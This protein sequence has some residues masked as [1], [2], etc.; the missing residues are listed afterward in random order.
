[1]ILC[2][3]EIQTRSY[4]IILSRIPT[5]EHPVAGILSC[6]SLFCHLE[7]LCWVCCPWSVV[8]FLHHN[9]C[10]PQIKVSICTFCNFYSTMFHSEFQ[11]FDVSFCN[12]N[13]WFT[14]RREQTFLPDFIAFGRILCWCFAISRNVKG[15][16]KNTVENCFDITV[17]LCISFFKRSAC[18]RRS[19]PLFCTL[20][21][22][23]TYP[24]KVDIVYCF[25]NVVCQAHRIHPSFCG[26]CG[27][28]TAAQF[29]HSAE[30]WAGPVKK[31][32]NLFDS[33]IFA[34]TDRTTHSA[35]IILFY[36]G[37]HLEGKSA[38][39]KTPSAAE[40]QRWNDKCP[41]V[42][43]DAGKHCDGKSVR[44]IHTASMYPID[45]NAADKCRHLIITYPSAQVN[46]SSEKNICIEWKGVLDGLPHKWIFKHRV[47]VT[48][49]SEVAQIFVTDVFKCST[50]SQ[51]IIWD[52]HFS[53]SQTR[54][55]SVGLSIDRSRDVLYSNGGLSIHVN[56]FSVHN[57]LWPFS[58]S[59]GYSGTVIE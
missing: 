12:L 48:L 22:P 56:R 29:C 44:I 38:G 39:Y 53:S 37:L 25:H 42:R 45:N 1:M 50:C 10:L 2:N 27:N 55:S 51:N 41:H 40:V 13:F 26:L 49:H 6:R 31:N 43:T 47:A 35:R 52:E 17:Y 23:F 14:L 3:I 21:Y 58:E 7:D 24:V 9:R 5:E 34:Q 54:N 46:I 57:G 33:E 11:L 28:C 8:R 32:P 18:C 30:Y 20:V 59:Q 15:P 36:V 4:E 16:C 19:L